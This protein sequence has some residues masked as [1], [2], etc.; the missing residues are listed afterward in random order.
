AEQVQRE[1]FDR[2]RLLR[3]AVCPRL[4]VRPFRPRLGTSGSPDRGVALST[5]SL[6]VV[7]SVLVETGQTN[8]QIGKLI[9]ASTFVTDFGTAAALSILFIQPNLWLLAFIGFSALAI[10]AMPRLE[11]WFFA[12][13]GNRVIEPEMKG[14]FAVLFALM[15]L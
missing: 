12:R 10:W 13:Y 3:G 11:P 7:Y 1:R 9:M 4:A 6:A 8:T 14:A 5:T 15:F 2:W